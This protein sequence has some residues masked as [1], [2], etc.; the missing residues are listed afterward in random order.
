MMTATVKNYTIEQGSTWKKVWVRLDDAE[1][2]IP[3]TGYTARMQARKSYTSDKVIDATTE[4]GK[5]SIN[6]ASGEVTLLIKASETAAIQDKTL[7]WDIELVK[8]EGLSTE[9]VF[10]WMQGTLTISKEVTK[11]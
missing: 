9:D 11:P 4:N 3:L 10:R 8:D 7:L 2:V 5:I 1:E 6:A